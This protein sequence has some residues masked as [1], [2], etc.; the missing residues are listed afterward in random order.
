M[1]RAAYHSRTKYAGKGATYN[2]AT[3]KKLRAQNRYASQR[4]SIPVSVKNAG[5]LVGER[6][7]VRLSQ[8]NREALT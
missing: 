8:R 2:H 4:P 6:V 3:T 1:S 7:F 5:Q